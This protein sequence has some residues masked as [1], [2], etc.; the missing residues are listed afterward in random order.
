[1]TSV[2]GRGMSLA[3]QAAHA[4]H[5]PERLGLVRHPV[6]LHAA[7]HL[8]P[9]AQRVGQPE[10]V[11]A[12]DPVRLH[13]VIEQLERRDAAGR[14]PGRRRLAPPRRAP[15]ARPCT[16]PSP[17]TAARSRS[18]SHAS[19]TCAW[20]MTSNVRPRTSSSCSSA[21][22]S[23]APPIRLPG[24]RTPFAIARILPSWGVSRVSTRS[25]SPSSNRDSTMAA[26][27]YVRGAGMQ[28]S[29]PV[30]GADTSVRAPATY[31]HQG[32]VTV[33]S[34]VDGALTRAGSAI[35]SRRAIRP[36]SRPS[37]C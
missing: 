34:P 30:P 6:A 2:G 1:M 23:T 4:G 35:R 20:V 25:A 3:Q 8:R 29:L 31:H 22:G 37:T 12:G 9:D 36:E 13:A 24:R 16:R 17:S 14:T 18:R 28:R 15:P 10:L 33:A 7:L 26:V 19:E 11:P 27:R 5:P 32:T 21:N